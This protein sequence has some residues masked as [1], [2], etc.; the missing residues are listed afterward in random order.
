MFGKFYVQEDFMVINHIRLLAKLFIYRW[1]LGKIKPSIDVF[2]AKLRQGGQFLKIM[3]CC[4]GGDVKHKILD[5]PTEL[6]R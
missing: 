2:K 3:W 4:V 6:I 5:L 1:K